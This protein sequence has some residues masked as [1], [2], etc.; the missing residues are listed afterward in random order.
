MRQL[1][2]ALGTLELW[3]CQSRVDVTDSAANLDEFWVLSP[4]IVH[5]LLLDLLI[6]LRHIIQMLDQQFGSMFLFPQFDD[7]V[8][9]QNLTGEVDCT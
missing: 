7:L 6:P 8:L 2:L 3:D 4:V 5:S 9:G 1:A